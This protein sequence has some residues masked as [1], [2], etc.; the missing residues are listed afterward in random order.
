M[1]KHHNHL[2]GFLKILISV[3]HSFGNPNLIFVCLFVCLRGLGGVHGIFNLK[4][5]PGVS[6][7]QQSLGVTAV[8]KVNQSWFLLL[9]TLSTHMTPKLVFGR[10]IPKM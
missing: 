4:I 7:K 6:D 2:E 1:G 10:E 5:S 9:A 8:D 3:F